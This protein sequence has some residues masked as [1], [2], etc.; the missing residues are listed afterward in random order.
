MVVT[1]RTQLT[2]RPTGNLSDIL[3]GF[4][5][6]FSSSILSSYYYTAATFSFQLLFL[7]SKPAFTDCSMAA[8]CLENLWEQH[9]SCLVC[10]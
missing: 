5:Y 8:P 7:L 6:I 10:L 3:S 1:V 4:P 2:G 9:S